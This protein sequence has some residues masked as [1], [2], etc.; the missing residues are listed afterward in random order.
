[1]DKYDLF[2]IKQDFWA[3]E[4]TLIIFRLFVFNSQLPSALAVTWVL[5]F[6]KLAETLFRL[7]PSILI[8]N[9]G[10]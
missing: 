8:Q 5:T 3:V 2:C 10:Y 4:T 1:M 9:K 6:A 7:F